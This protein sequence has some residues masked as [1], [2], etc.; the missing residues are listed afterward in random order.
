MRVTNQQTNE[1]TNFL[2]NFRCSKNL[3]NMKKIYTLIV[4][5]ALVLAG[6]GSSKKQVA[7]GNYEAA[8][9]KAVKALRKDSDSEKDI[10]AL[11][12]AMNVVTEQDN[13]RI[14][15]L[16]IEGKASS[17]DEIYQIYKRMNDRQTLVRTVTPLELDG[18]RIEFPYVDYLSEIATAKRNAADFYYA[19]GQELMK[20]NT[21][22]SYRQAYNEFVRAQQYVGDY[23]GIDAMINESQYMGMSHVFVNIKNYSGINFPETFEQDLLALDLPSLN[24]DWVQYYTSDLD[25]SINFDYVVNV[26]LK[27]IAVSPDKQEQIDS[28][29][30][31]DIEDGF[32]YVLDSKG[33]V[34]RDTAGNDIKIKKYKTVQCAMV[35]TIQTKECVIEGD[36][37]IV[38][39]VP[40]KVIK[41]DPI[42]AMSDFE[43]I[44]ARAIGDQNALTERHKQ[45]INSKIVPFPTDLDMVIMCSENLKKAIRGIMYQNA[46]YIY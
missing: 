10:I 23:P 2:F 35:Q 6:C 26:N 21:K 40:E 38:T 46:R 25:K 12:K 41:K 17:W 31:R 39:L 45:M 43:H 20:N 44:S 36:V 29:I 27:N 22:E 33:N 13:E 14:R 30:K 24:S 28:L 37:E 11:E 19:H 18:R 1:I 9:Q 4:L 34:M 15:Y 42:G 8:I 32:Q 7:A 3:G 5:V 16:K